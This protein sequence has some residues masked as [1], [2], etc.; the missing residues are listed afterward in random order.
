MSHLFVA[1]DLRLKIEACWNQD[2][3][4]ERKLIVSTLRS[5]LPLPCRQFMRC[6]P[7]VTFLNL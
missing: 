6:P 3:P 4:L 7:V 1:K 5:L 2:I